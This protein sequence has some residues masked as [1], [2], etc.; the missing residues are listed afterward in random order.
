MIYHKLINILSLSNFDL[1]SYLYKNDKEMRVYLSSDS[2]C[3]GTHLPEVV[4][5]WFC[6]AIDW[7]GDS[8]QEDKDVRE[9][10]WLLSFASDV[11]F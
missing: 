9:L 5:L 4:L 11:S 1:K 6:S 2:E 8:I 10:Y 7:G 3:E